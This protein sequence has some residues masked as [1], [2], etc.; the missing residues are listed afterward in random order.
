MRTR[1]TKK[2]KGKEMSDRIHVTMTEEDGGW[3][4]V[5]CNTARLVRFVC[6]NRESAS[7]IAAVAREVLADL[8]LC[9][10][11]DMADFIPYAII[12]CV[13][14]HKLSESEIEK[15]FKILGEE[16]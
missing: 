13:H 2:G 8:E 1:E 6:E 10:D 4:P 3:F 11:D 7:R 5:V 16:D 9:L 14:W 12:E 15:V